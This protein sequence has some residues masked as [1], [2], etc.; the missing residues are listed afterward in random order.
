[1]RAARD[2][3]IKPEDRVSRVRSVGLAGRVV[4]QQR[5]FWRPRPARRCLLPYKFVMLSSDHGRPCVGPLRCPRV[6]V[7]AEPGS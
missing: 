7:V 5:A 6:V 3:Q 4:Y 2:A 1:M